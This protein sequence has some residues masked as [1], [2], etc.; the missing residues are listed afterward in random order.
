MDAYRSHEPHEGP[1]PGLR[2]PSPHPMGKGQGEGTV[3]GKR[4]LRLGQCSWTEV[5]RA[6]PAIGFRCS[7]RAL[8]GLNRSAEHRL[9]SLESWRQLAGLV[10]GAPIPCRIRGAKRE[11]DLGE[12]SL[13]PKGYRSG[14]ASVQPARTVNSTA[15]VSRPAPH[16]VPLP[17]RRGEGGRRPGEGFPSVPSEVSGGLHRWFRPLGAGGGLATR[18]MPPSERS[19]TSRRSALRATPFFTLC[20]RKLIFCAPDALVADTQT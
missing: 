3:H 5:S 9:G 15:S 1:S 17:F 19:V 13:L 7:R 14:G 8:L 20:G 2:P 12:I 16:P 11:T 4:G 10:L 6:N 18:V